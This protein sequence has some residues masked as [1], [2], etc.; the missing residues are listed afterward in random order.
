MPSRVGSAIRALKRFLPTR[1]YSGISSRQPAHT[2]A[3]E[4]MTA[5]VHLNRPMQS[6]DRS[7]GRAPCFPRS[8]KNDRPEWI[9]RFSTARF[10]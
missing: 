3:G 5:T 6:S 8:L 4:Q 2:S 7:E 10:C 1:P 9:R